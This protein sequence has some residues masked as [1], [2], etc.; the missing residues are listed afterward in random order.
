M[1]VTQTRSKILE[2]KRKS[3]QKVTDEK[4]CFI[5]KLLFQSTRLPGSKLQESVPCKLSIV[6]KLVGNIRKMGKQ[7]VA[8][9]RNNP[10]GTPAAEYL[11]V[12]R[13]FTAIF[14]FF[15]FVN[16][17]RSLQELNVLIFRRS[18]NLKS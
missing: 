18:C 6:Y 9:S 16:F 14:C 11:Q 3:G 8:L 10:L 4:F 17:L 12:A 7:N 1:R 15:S 2:G 13:F 5:H